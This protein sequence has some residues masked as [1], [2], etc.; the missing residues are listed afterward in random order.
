MGARVRSLWE[1]RALAVRLGLIRGHRALISSAVSLEGSDAMG[2]FDYYEPDPA[3]ACPV[4]RAP[5]AGWQGKDGPCALLVWRQGVA[6]PVDQAVPE[7]S[8]GDRPVL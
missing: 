2:M 7:E 3:L 4:C 1:G 8:K 5:L 6:S